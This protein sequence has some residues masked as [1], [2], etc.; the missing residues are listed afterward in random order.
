[1]IMHD[2]INT[3]SG[4]VNDGSKINIM[5]F[6]NSTSTTLQS[7]IE[8]FLDVSKQGV[9][10]IHR[11]DDVVH[12]MSA[13]FA[14]LDNIKTIADE[15]SMLALNAT[16]EAAHAGEAGRGFSVVAKEV[17][18]LAQYSRDFNAKVL[19]QVVNAQEIIN[20]TRD[21]VGQ[22]ISKDL[23]FAIVA[24]NQ[25]VSMLAEIEIINQTVSASLSDASVLSG[26]ISNDVSIA[27]RSLQFEDI[28]RQ[29]LDHTKERIENISRQISL[30]SSLFS[31]LTSIKNSGTQESVSL[32]KI[33]QEFQSC[34]NNMSKDSHKPA[35]QASVQA[36]DI[37]LF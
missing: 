6:T 4:N 2:V 28:V 18:K 22:L 3:A 24:K 16:I 19:D 34:L 23:S 37:D 29:Q 7:F 15:T 9:E 26:E 36:G 33:K 25:V 13:V 20:N 31:E 30:L 12:A 27:V 32:E 17:S 21:I 10:S 8:I 35:L 5:T 11:I 14:L 1:M